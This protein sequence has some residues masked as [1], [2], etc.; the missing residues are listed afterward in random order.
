MTLT[1]F[2]TSLTSSPVPWF[3]QLQ[4]AS[5]RG[6][7]FVVER[8][9]GEFGRRIA[10]HEYPF[11]DTIWPED[12]GRAPRRIEVSGFII[13]DDVIAQKE[14]M[15]AAAEQKGPGILIHP[16]LGQLT[17]TLLRLRP[18]ARKDRGR[19]F[20]LQFS[21]VEAGQRLFP[22][23][24]LATGPAVLAA[25][26]AVNSAASGDFV[27]SAA[28]ALLQGTAIALMA[29]GTVNTWTRIA[30]S[31]ADDATNL[32]NMV[33]TLTGNYGRYFAGANAGYTGTTKSPA[34]VTASI[35][36]LILAGNSAR[37][38]VYS[39]AASAN[40]T[41]SASNSPAD[42]A[43]AIQNL[44]TALLAACVDP[45]DAIRILTQL[46]DFTP[47]QPVP[48][49]QQ[50]QAMGTIQTSTGD[51][52]RR[53]ALAALAEAATNYQPSSYDDAANLRDTLCALLD[54]EITIAG[55]EGEDDTYSAFR[56]LRVAVVQDLTARG[57]NLA[58][59]ITFS[60]SQPLPALVL[61]NRIY[62]DASRDDQ[63]VTQVNPVHPSFMPVSFQALAN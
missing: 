7:P 15:I 4:P 60:F 27:T 58:H 3:T 45:A 32:K 61:A 19:C 59:I 22:S 9:E 35:A 13:G 31:L 50:G 53:A 14:R 6:I 36:D 1:S 47:N 38:N 52:C 55:D 48:S 42:I 39:A 28:A 18:V 34:S 51:L 33:S 41:A 16:S 37:A 62:R 5:W 43:A 2:L 10:E 29:V 24:I 11:R 56:E 44:A 54:A 23:L 25:A 49:S 57:A 20:E 8:D 46:A 30:T 63:L 12:L 17:V 21:F 26:G 40:T